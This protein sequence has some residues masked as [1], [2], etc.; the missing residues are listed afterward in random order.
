MMAT[1][2]KGSAS[3]ALQISRNSTISIR[4]SPFSNLETKDCG[5]P[6]AAARAVC[7]N[8]ASFLADTRQRS[9]AS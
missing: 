6:S 9:I 5:R 3:N 8:P 2:G 1:I 4:L 7:V